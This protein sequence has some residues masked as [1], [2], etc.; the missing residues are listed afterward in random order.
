MAEWHIPFWEIEAN[1]DD[2]QL[3]VLVRRLNERW[4]AQSKQHKKGKR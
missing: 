2:A 3:S 4:A 1:M